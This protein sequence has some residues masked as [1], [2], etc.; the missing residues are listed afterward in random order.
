MFVNL[1]MMGCGESCVYGE[2]LIGDLLGKIS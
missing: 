2:V 1:F